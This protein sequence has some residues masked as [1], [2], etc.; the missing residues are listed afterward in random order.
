[1]AVMQMDIARYQTRETTDALADQARKLLLIAIG[2]QIAFLIP[3]LLAYLLDERLLNGVGVWSKPI[4]FQTSI[5][6]TVGTLILLLP[7][8]DEAVR[9]TRVVRWSAQ[10]IAIAG[11]LEIVYIVLQ[12]ARARASHFNN[13]TPLEM[14]LYSVMG[15]GAVTIVVGCFVFGWM[16]WRHGRRDMGEGLRFGATWGLMIGAVL[17]VITA[18]LLSSGALAEPGHWVG[19][20]RSDADGL[21]LVGWSRTG[22]DL[23]VPH[24][25]ATHIMQALPLLGLLLDRWAPDK[26][27]AGIWIGAAASVLVVAATFAQAAMGKPFL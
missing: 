1:M 20:V 8:L 21:F 13:D 11:T 22:G 19:G 7:L 3:S 23:R 6:I 10:A 27:R 2:I 5:A 4:K 15:V 14:M 9:A 16:I 12:A 25:F 24:F 26:A 17:T 18:G